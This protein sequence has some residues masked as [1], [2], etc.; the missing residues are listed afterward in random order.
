VLAKIELGESGLVRVIDNCDCRRLVLSA[1]RLW[2]KCDCHLELVVGEGAKVPQLEAGNSLEIPIEITGAQSPIKAY[3]G[4]GVSVSVS[5]DNPSPPK[6]K[7]T[8]QAEDGA[9]TG[10][11]DV[12]LTDANCSTMSFRINVTPA[13]SL[14]SPQA[15]EKSAKKE[16]R[17]KRRNR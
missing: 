15:D 5:P 16:V 7:L 10:E 12:I 3:A 13:A 1:A 6:W 14:E 2:W 17:K 11:R 8:L 4:P 9:K